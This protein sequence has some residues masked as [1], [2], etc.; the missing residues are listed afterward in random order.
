MITWQ[1]GGVGEGLEVT[2]GGVYGGFWR[3]LNIL[4]HALDSGYML[5]HFTKMGSCTLSIFCALF[6]IKFLQTK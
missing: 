4:S 1:E 6:C 3:L 2:R 5:V